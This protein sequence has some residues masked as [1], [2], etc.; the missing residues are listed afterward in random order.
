MQYP[1]NNRI[2]LYKE[3][4][5][6]FSHCRFHIDILLKQEASSYHEPQP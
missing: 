1:K 5:E 4:K 2:K 6:E 3:T